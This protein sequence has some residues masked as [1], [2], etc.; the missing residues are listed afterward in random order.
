MTVPTHTL[1]LVKTRTDTAECKGKT[2]SLH[3]Y[4]VRLDGEE[5]G[6]VRRQIMNR[7]RLAYPQAP[8]VLA[9]W[10]SPGWEYRDANARGTWSWLEVRS[11]AE[12]VRRL[13]TL[14]AGVDRREADV[15]EKSVRSVR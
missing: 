4:S 8:I 12:G 6:Q 2:I 15:L 11:R 13:L 1:E 14:F 7:E 10:S 9:R 5:I 3:T